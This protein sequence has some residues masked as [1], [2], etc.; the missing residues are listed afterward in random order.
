MIIPFCF[1][2]PFGSVSVPLRWLLCLFGFCIFLLF[3]LLL[4]FSFF[5][6]QEVKSFVLFE[7]TVLLTTRLEGLT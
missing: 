2:A 4:A 3:F 6:I 5:L 7:E 1:R